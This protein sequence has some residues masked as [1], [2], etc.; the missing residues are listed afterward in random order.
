MSPFWN[1]SQKVYRTNVNHSLLELEKYDM[2][3]KIK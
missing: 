2:M 1:H 3:G